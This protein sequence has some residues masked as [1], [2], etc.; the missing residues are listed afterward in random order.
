MVL[1]EELN[2]YVLIY[3]ITGGSGFITSLHIHL[4]FCSA[5]SLIVVNPESLQLL[6][7]PACVVSSVVPNKSATEW[8]ASIFNPA[9]TTDEDVAMLRRG[10]VKMKNT[11][12]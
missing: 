3:N 8:I 4:I 5:G 9:K 10:T 6:T 2:I 12:K 7:F 11:S 1:E